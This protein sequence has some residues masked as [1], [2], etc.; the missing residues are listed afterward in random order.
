[1]SLWWQLDA[2]LEQALA[3]P[4]V[5]SRKAEEIKVVI[6]LMAYQRRATV[7]DLV[8]HV[9]RCLYGVVGG[10]QVFADGRWQPIVAQRE[11]VVVDISDDEADN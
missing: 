9:T 5:R 2:F 10:R 7:T 4:D 11:V 1:M 3:H 6:S 8:G